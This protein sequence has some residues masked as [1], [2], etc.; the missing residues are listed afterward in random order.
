MAA[1]TNKR[2]FG[3]VMFWTVLTTLFAWLPLVRII[4]RPEGYTWQIL[5]LSGSG[6]EGPFWV[7]VPLTAYAVALLYT[8]GRGPRAWFHPLLILWHL[9]VTG[10]I[11]TALVQAGRDAFW[12]GQA[13]HLTIPMWIIVVP[14]LVFTVLALVWVAQD[15]RQPATPV[16]PWCRTNTSRLV[17]SLVLL[18]V[19][20]VLFRTG[21]NYNW[22]TA[23]AVVTTVL[24]WIT[25]AWS[26][27]SV[28]PAAT[29][30]G[31]ATSAPAL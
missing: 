11:I 27:E 23:V 4:A 25:L 7:F 5:G 12:Q 17:G 28:E 20:F 1:T 19:G 31:N 22:V 24:H 2:L 13:L 10:V 14:T 9:T 30:T 18:M 6:L 29:S 16:A 15:R 21:T 3:V 8:A 26:F